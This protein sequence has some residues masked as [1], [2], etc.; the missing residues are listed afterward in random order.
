MWRLSKTS[1]ANIAWLACRK[2]GNTSC[3]TEHCHGTQ[4]NH[5][6][7]SRAPFWLCFDRRRHRRSNREHGSG[8]LVRARSHPQRSK[9]GNFLAAA[10]P[11][12]QASYDR[13]ANASHDGQCCNRA[14]REHDD[15][16]LCIAIHAVLHTSGAQRPAG[17]AS[18]VGDNLEFSSL[19][20]TS[21]KLTLAGALATRTRNLGP[22]PIEG[23]VVSRSTSAAPFPRH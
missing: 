15:L 20:G 11:G 5:R 14:Q 7:G 18:F 17:S 4:R 9:P 16:V 1:I 3:R 19:K 21:P 12:E 23:T 2:C 6:L 22:P 8:A 13:K 10:L